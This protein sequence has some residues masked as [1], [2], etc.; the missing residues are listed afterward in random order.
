MRLLAVR[1]ALSLSLSLGVKLFRPFSHVDPGSNRVIWI[2]SRVSATLAPLD[3]I[4][5]SINLVSR[6]RETGVSSSVPSGILCRRISL[7]IHTAKKVARDVLPAKSRALFSFFS[8]GSP[9]RSALRNP[10]V[11]FSSSPLSIRDPQ[12]AG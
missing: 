4:P 12:I 10:A 3:I 11:F 8:S 2:R 9:W 5:P 7:N 6:S 1:R